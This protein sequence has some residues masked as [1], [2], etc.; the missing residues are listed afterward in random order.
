[1]IYPVTSAKNQ[2]SINTILTRLSEVSDEKCTPS[3]CD[4]IRLNKTHNNYRII[5]SMSK[6]FLQNE[7]IGLDFDFNE[8]FCLFNKA[9]V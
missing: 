5:I 6:M 7:S 8:A 3:D 9:N 4:K 2:R 1:M